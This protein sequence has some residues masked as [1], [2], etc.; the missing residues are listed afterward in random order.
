[1]VPDAPRTIATP[2]QRLAGRLRANNYILVEPSGQDGRSCQWL[3]VVDQLESCGALLRGQTTAAQF[4]E[5][6]IA[7]LVAHQ[8]DVVSMHAQRNDMAGVTLLRHYWTDI[9]FRRAV[10]VQGDQGDHCSLAVILAMIKDVWG[11]HASVCISDWRGVDYDTT[12]YAPNRY[13][14]VPTVSIDLGYIG[15]HYL[16]VVALCLWRR[17]SPD[18]I[19]LHGGRLEVSDRAFGGMIARCTRQCRRPRANQIT[20][21]RMRADRVRDRLSFRLGAQRLAVIS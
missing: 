6:L 17:S 16:S 10:S 7:W 8:G 13:D 14:V 12:V 18:D 21:P 19:S 2:H 15:N 5:K 4:E 1:M 20:W 3:A 9:D 11:V